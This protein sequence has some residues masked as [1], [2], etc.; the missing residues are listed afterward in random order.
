[1]SYQIEIYKGKGGQLCKRGNRVIY[2]DVVKEGI[3]ARGR[4]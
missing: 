3:Y 1:M 2:P 4:S